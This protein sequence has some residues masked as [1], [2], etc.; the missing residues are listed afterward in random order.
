MSNVQFAPMM[1]AE[2]HQGFVE[3]RAK[4]TTDGLENVAAVFVPVMPAE[5]ASPRILIVGKATRDFGDGDLATFEGACQRDGELLNELPRGKTSFWQFARSI[6]EKTLEH[7]GK[8]HGRE[9]LVQHCAWTNLAKIG[10]TKGNPHRSSIEA[11]HDLCRRAL[12]TEI[13]RFMPD[14]IV[15]VSSLWARDSIVRPVFE[16]VAKPALELDEGW[17]LGSRRPG[18]DRVQAVRA[19][20]ADLDGPPSGAQGAP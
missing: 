1:T 16:E 18:P 5:P 14:A 13:A 9:D 11:Q 17:A 2:E 12:R 3:I 19:R 10:D 15:L 20:R 8:P 7:L 6:T 4:L